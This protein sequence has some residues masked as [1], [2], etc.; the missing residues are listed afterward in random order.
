MLPGPQATL[1]FM[2]KEVLSGALFY[3]LRMTMMRVGI[4]FVVAMLAGT[5]LGAA[6]GY[7]RSVD[8]LLS[9]WLVTG[10]TIPRIL[11]FVM[12]YLMV[13]LNE[14]AAISALTLTV[15]PTVVVQVREGTKA[16]DNKLLE[17]ARAYRRPPA[18][19][20]QHVIFPQLLPFIIGTARVALSLTWKMVT[21]AEL[22]GRTNGVG[23]QIA[24]YFQMF[25]M[26]G[27]L[28]YGVAMMLV[29]AAIDIAFTTLMQTFFRWRK[30]LKT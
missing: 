10:L 27:I 23:Y 11:L 25:N 21:L 12:A 19:I 26:T 3:H 22:I 14:S 7:F 6:S 24:F 15:L 16:I 20:W 8:A 9:S 4:A 2:W 30:P 18:S 1:A 28:A 29:L 17:M 5:V 13:G